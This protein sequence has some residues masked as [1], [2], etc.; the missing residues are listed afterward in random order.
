MENVLISVTPLI[1]KRKKFLLKTFLK[2]LKPKLQIDEIYP[3]GLIGEF[4]HCFFAWKM[5]LTK[6]AYIRFS[7]K[8]IL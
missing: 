7:K 6:N 8:K 3:L 5:H 1:F 4:K 2:H